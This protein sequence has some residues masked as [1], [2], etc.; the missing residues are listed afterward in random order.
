MPEIDMGAHLHPGMTAIIKARLS[1]QTAH[2]VIV[3]GTRYP[4]E[5]ALARGIV[6]HAVGEEEVLARAVEVAASLAE[7]A[8]PIM[9]RLK[10]DMY[11]DVLDALGR[12]LQ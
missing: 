11:A 2:E 3:T 7:K 9:A 10:G 4:A 12:D 6:D 5:L 8:K 1:A